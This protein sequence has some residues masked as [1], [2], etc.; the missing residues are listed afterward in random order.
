MGALA[1]FSNVTSGT[2]NTLIGQFTRVPTVTGNGQISINN[3]IVATGATDTGNTYGAG[4]LGLGNSAPAAKL[5]VTGT[6]S[7]TDVL[8]V[9]GASGQT[10]P[11]QKW[12]DASS[13]VLLSVNKDG[14]LL[15]SGTPQTLTGAGAV[16]LTT[17]GTLL[18]TT[19][20]DALTLAAGTEG[21]TK[22]IRMKTDGGDGTL[23]VTNGQGFTT[24]TFNDAGDFVLLF[25][26][27][28]KWHILTNSGCITA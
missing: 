2:R 16:N 14:M 23:T 20:A 28:S 12:T 22:F 24:I 25:Y 5:H 9:Q 10:A 6:A 27:D 19:G 4:Q 11:L 18:V 15:Q 13:N 17:Y 26:L 3:F 1:G 21:Q 8:T 7:G